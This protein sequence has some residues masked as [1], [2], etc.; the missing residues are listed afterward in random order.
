MVD[1]ENQPPNTSQPIP[2]KYINSFHALSDKFQLSD[3]APIEVKVRANI[4][5]LEQLDRSYFGKD[6]VRKIREILD[7]STALL[8]TKPIDLV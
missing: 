8:D 1:V 2:G 6:R 3:D 7:A 4:T 5:Q